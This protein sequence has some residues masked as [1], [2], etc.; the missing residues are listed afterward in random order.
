MM[1]LES[2]NT[3]FS[4]C[5]ILFFAQQKLIKIRNMII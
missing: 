1:L 2:L 5:D 3:S 4:I